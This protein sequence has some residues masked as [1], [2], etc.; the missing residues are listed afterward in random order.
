MIFRRP[1]LL[2]ALASL[3]ASTSAS[4]QTQCVV[5]TPSLDNTLFESSTGDLS[6]GVGPRGFVGATGM[7][8]IRRYL[9]QFDVAGAIPAGSTIDSAT[10]R[11]RTLQLA[12]QGGPNFFQDV[13]R[14]TQAWGEGSSN[15]GNS[16]QGAPSTTGDATWIHA[17]KPGALWANAGGDFDPLSRGTYNIVLVGQATF[18]TGAMAADVQDWLVNPATNHGWMLKSSSETPNTAVAIASR[19]ANDPTQVPTL[20]I[21]YTPPAGTLATFCDPADNNSTGLPTVLTA[22][23]GSGTGSGVHLEA[24]QGPPGQFGYVL[25]GTKSTEV[26]LAIGSGHLCL[27]SASPQQIGRYNVGG[28]ALDSIGV[29]DGAGVLQNLVGTS[30]VGTGFDVPNTIP[31]A[32]SPMISAGD[33][34]HFQLWHREN[35]GDSNF[36][37]GVSAT[38]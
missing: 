3:L 10:L 22:T 34:W 36:S 8:A 1:I 35:G 4:A 30:T 26:G 29:F 17:V 27:E 13:H 33:T 11:F 31:F 20:T 32:S 25:V 14:V 15:S 19:E 21:E 28:G 38:F 23:L 16:G 24:S 5:L 9:V 18:G 7:G 12:S 37:N 6:S 2:G